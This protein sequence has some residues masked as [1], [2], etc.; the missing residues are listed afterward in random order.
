MGVVPLHSTYTLIQVSLN[1]EKIR[2]KR[3]DARAHVVAR[4][5]FSLQW[6]PVDHR[7]D[8]STDSSCTHNSIESSD[9]Q[10]TERKEHIYLV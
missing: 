6:M 10:N 2:R 7:L 4:H 9:D 8:T 1:G 3:V 5:R